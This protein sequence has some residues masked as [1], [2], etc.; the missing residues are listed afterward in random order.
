MVSIGFRKLGLVRRQ[1]RLRTPSSFHLSTLVVGSVLLMIVLSGLYPANGRHH[2]AQPRALSYILAMV[3]LLLYVSY[4]RR[5][6]STD[7]KT[8]LAM[9]TTGIFLFCGLTVAAWVGETSLSNSIGQMRVI[10]V[11]VSTCSAVIFVVHHG[12]V[13]YQTL[14]RL[15]LHLTLAYSAIKIGILL[16]WL[17]GL[18]DIREFCL[19]TLG[20]KP[21][22]GSFQFFGLIR[23]QTALD[24]LQPYLWFYFLRR[25]QLDLRLSNRY[26]WLFGLITGLSILISFSRM[27]WAITLILTAVSRLTQPRANPI[28]TLVRAALTTCLVLGVIGATDTGQSIKK[29]ISSRATTNSDG[30]RLRQVYDMTQKITTR[31]LLGSGLGASCAYKS[32]KAE[33]QWVAFMMQFGIGGMTIIFLAIM[34]LFAPYLL[35]GQLSTNMPYFLLPILWLLAGFSNPYLLSLNSGLMY[36]IFFLT[37]KALRTIEKERKQSRTARTST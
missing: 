17:I 13:T 22:M 28:H 19:T 37:P 2:A 12:L 3:T 16:G 4:R 29:R 30:F 33:V 15:I 14:L 18:Y 5:L 27:L 25:D 6:D 20:L 9:A 31:P 35:K 8:L 24:V 21:M 7:Q 1:F 34:V 32:Y 10:I 26:R 11:T 36:A 23:F